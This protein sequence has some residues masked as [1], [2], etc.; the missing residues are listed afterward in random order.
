MFR[1]LRYAPLV[2]LLLMT[3]GCA[4]NYY[5]VP[6][7]SYEKKVRVLGIAPFFTDGDSDI[8]HPE[9]EALLAM[10][11]EQNQ[12]NGAELVARLKETGAYLSVRMPDD[13]ADQL[14]SSLFFRRERRSDAGVVYNKYFFKQQELKEFI[15]RNSLDAVMLVTVSGLTRPDKVYSGNYL[16]Y[17][18]TDFN[19][20]IMTAQ[21]L[22]GD[23][24]IL[25]EYPN[26]QQRLLSLTPLLNLQYA[27]FDEA[28]ANVTDKVDTKLKTIP[29]ITR[30]FGKDTASSVQKDRKISMLYSAIFDEM[31]ATLR[32]EFRFPWERDREE[33]KGEQPTR[34]EPAAAASTAKKA[35]PKAVEVAIPR[36]EPK[37][38]K[39]EPAAIPAEP[40]PLAPREIRT[41][42]LR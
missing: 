14:F 24:N 17:L 21:I 26:F 19:F 11:R 3:V 23:G 27:D 36:A 5:N 9:R 4:H 40:A 8:R 1:F 15:E 42:D 20:L 25:W 13:Q 12:R 39:A 31:V 37:V 22:D 35:E 30:A 34:P 41:E 18:E 2:A 28:E 32:P 7:E 33:R 38:I 6:R 10:V 29:G 16:A